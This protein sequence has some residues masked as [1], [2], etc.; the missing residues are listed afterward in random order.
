[1]TSSRRFKC[2]FCPKSFDNIVSLDLHIRRKHHLSIYSINNSE[3][4]TVKITIKVTPTDKTILI[5]AAD[6]AGVP[7]SV[8]IRGIITEYIRKNRLRKLL[9]TI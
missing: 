3:P 1:M 4:L 6:A 5:R 2:P 7:L 8:F 9:N